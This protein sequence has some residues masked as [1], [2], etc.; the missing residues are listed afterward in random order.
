ML[1]SLTGAETVGVHGAGPLTE[2]VSVRHFRDSAGYSIQSPR[3]AIKVTIPG[4]VEAPLNHITGLAS[5]DGL[6]GAAVSGPDVP[7]NAV[8]SSIIVPAVAAT[9]TVPGMPGSVAIEF[10]TVEAKP[11]NGAAPLPDAPPPAPVALDFAIPSQ[12]VVFENGVSRLIL[13]P[14]VA[15]DALTVTLAP[16]PV[17]GQL[18]I[19]YTDLAIAALTVLPNA[20]QKMP[21][22][23]DDK[24]IPLNDDDARKARLIALA[25]NT[26][27]GFLYSASDATWYRIQ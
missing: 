9:N 19:I 13:G 15:L 2:T 27:V 24:G 21:V 10:P 14:P 16:N 22:L 23:K 17:D 18:A 4:V 11:E 25:I 8:V 3:P 12:A 26:S 5:T 7:P 20:G 1:N 6:L